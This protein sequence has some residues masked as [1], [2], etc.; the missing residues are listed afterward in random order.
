MIRPSP[1]G[2]G[3]GLRRVQQA[4]SIAELYSNLRL[5]S[6]TP[7]SLQSAVSDTPD[8]DAVDWPLAQVPV[9]SGSSTWWKERVR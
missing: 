8:D 7:R 9:S 5:P 1:F 3:D 4:G 2:T 6:T